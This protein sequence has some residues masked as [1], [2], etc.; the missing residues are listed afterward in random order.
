MIAT[1]LSVPQVLVC[2]M[3]SLGEVCRG[4]ETLA[5][6]LLGP[7]KH[8]RG[9]HSLQDYGGLVVTAP[10]CGLDACYLAHDRRLLL[11]LFGLLGVQ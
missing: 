8:L 4:G 10:G 11:T 6:G 2:V 5:T 1:H 9:I 7:P 3:I